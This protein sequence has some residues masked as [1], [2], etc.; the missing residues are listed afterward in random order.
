MTRDRYLPALRFSALTCFFDPLIRCVLPERRFK[1]RLLEQA[2]IGPGQRIL[3]LGCGTGTLAIMVK[4]ANPGAD[5]LG[6]DAD[7][8][9]L[10]LAR[11][12]ADAEG[13]EVRFDHGLSTELPY[14]RPA[15]SR[16]CS[17]REARFTLPTGDG[18]PIR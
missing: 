12:K 15:R 11:S 18:R 17:G 6:L 4:S 3:D 5:V 13:A 7:P 16:A 8:D 14:E 2:A 1:Q 9:I 10:A